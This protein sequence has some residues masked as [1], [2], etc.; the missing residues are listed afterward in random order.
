MLEAVILFW[1]SAAGLFY[2][3]LGYP[4]LIG[5]LASRFPRPVRKGSCDASI[6]VIIA[7]HHEAPRIATKINNILAAEGSDRIREILIGSDGCTDQ[8]AAALAAIHD[9]RVRLI[10]FPERRGKP[11][12]LNDLVPQA[13]GEVIVFMDVRQRLDQAALPALLANFA[14]PAVGVVSG[15]L[16][17]EHDPSQSGTAAG[18]DAY[19]RYEKWIRDREG[20][21]ASVPGATGALYAIRRE[22]VMPIPAEVALDDVFI[23]MNAIARGYRCIFEPEARI[24][25]RVAL[26]AAREAVRKRRT[27]A[28]NV[29][30]L[31]LHPQWCLPGGH[32]AWWQFASHKIARLLSPF[33]LIMAF[34]TSLIML[35]HPFYRF[36]AI[37][38]A[39]VWGIGGLQ[40]MGMGPSRGRVGKLAG[41]IAVFLVMQAHSLLAWRDGLTNR[42][43]VQWRKVDTLN[44]TG[45][46]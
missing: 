25:D 38:Q 39:L 30:L 18:I 42:N 37:G 40:L 26:D 46:H 43:L 35:A 29:Q 15:E 3:Y 23:P 2:I 16:V 36:A 32:P 22:L 19:W 31:R 21:W 44:F 28:G 7:I 11:S 33:L 45:K 5:L 13:T 41:W 14:D 4:L 34:A 1:F 9:P 27:L 6:S 12:V 10:I 8:P 20:R 17:F 24:Y